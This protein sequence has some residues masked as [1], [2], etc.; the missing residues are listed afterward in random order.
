MKSI[1][2]YMD[3]LGIEYFDNPTARISVIQELNDPF[4]HDLSASIAN[5]INNH[6]KA[7]NNVR[8]ESGQNKVS[9]DEVKKY[10]FN[11]QRGLGVISFS[12]TNRNLLMWAHYANNHSGIC[13]EVEKDWSE[14]KEKLSKTPSHD[15]H[16]FTRVQYD[17]RRVDFS[18]IRSEDYTD[19]DGIILDLYVKQLTL[20][21]DE[22][23]YEKEHRNIMSIFEADY[24]KI[25]NGAKLSKATSNK[26]NSFIKEES[27]TK[28]TNGYEMTNCENFDIFEHI[29]DTNSFIYLTKFPPKKI[30]SVYLG[31]RFCNKMMAKLIDK[32][33]KPEHP[34]HHITIHKCSISN[35]RFEIET[36]VI[37]EP[38]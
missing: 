14:S 1:Y 23:M 35:T 36:K 10:I 24:I 12:E 19:I 17:T 18:E 32:I 11:A 2:K 25:K 15:L 5:L 29:V 38:S 31:H 9:E 21:S 22:W 37:Y 20:K 30:K 27:I 7:I 13:I 8:L 16:R 3:F 26:L 28:G 4:E 34:L 6:T 33:K